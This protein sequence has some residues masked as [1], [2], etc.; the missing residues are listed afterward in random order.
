MLL[1]ITNDAWYGR[2]GAPVPVPRDDRAARGGEPRLWTARAAN[3]GVSALID[4]RGHGA[5]R[6]RE[7]SSE[8]LLVGDVALAAP[9]GP[10]T[11]YV[12][13]GDWLAGGVLGR[14][15]AWRSLRARRRRRRVDAA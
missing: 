11:F 8:T 1:A 15:S 14:S 13:H 5:E 7:S 12:R 9:D 10:P 4:E 6:R 2:T 3:T